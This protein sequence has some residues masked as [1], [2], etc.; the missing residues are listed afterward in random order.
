MKKIKISKELLDALN[1][2]EFYSANSYGVAMIL[3]EVGDMEITEKFVDEISL[4]SYS[5]Q[6]LHRIAARGLEIL[7][8]TCRQTM[9]ALSN[10]SPESIGF[11]IKHAPDNASSDEML[12]AAVRNRA[13]GAQAVRVLLGLRRIDSVCEATVVSSLENPKHSLSLLKTFEDR[14]GPLVLSQDAFVAAAKSNCPL[15]VIKFV[16]GRCERFSVTESLVIVLLRETS[17]GLG[18]NLNLLLEY[19]PN[20]CV[21]DELIAETVVRVD[22]KYLLMLYLHHGKP[23]VLTEKVL[24]AIAQN[25]VFDGFIALDIILRHTSGAKV[26]NTMVLEAMRSPHSTELITLILERDPSISIQEESLMAAASNPKQGALTLQAL[27]DKGRINF[28][29][30]TTGDT[31]APPTNRRKISSNRSPLPRD[32]RDKS[33]QITKKVI[34]AAAS[35]VNEDQRQLLLCWFEK[36]GVLTEEDGRLFRFS[37]SQSSQSSDPSLSDPDS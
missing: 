18:P 15:D 6:L 20:F 25:P 3:F 29:N 1:E 7:P 2:R 16:L 17:Y 23:L 22:A 10:G 9:S 31:H 4:L 28:G 27:Y 34:E 8:L 33:A 11:F 14:W 35:N 21:Q 32:T 30:L 24:R 26:S 19:D 12:L 37:E 5:S 36:W 13:Y